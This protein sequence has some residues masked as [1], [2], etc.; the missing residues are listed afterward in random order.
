[1]LDFLAVLG[2]DF[3]VIVS[4]DVPHMVLS[5][6]YPMDPPYLPR[7]EDKNI[8]ELRQVISLRFSKIFYKAKLCRIRNN[9]IIKVL[10]QCF[11]RSIGSDNDSVANIAVHHR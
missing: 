6:C 2:R 7:Q 10:T 3:G 4:I 8:S 5:V 9:Q 1:M 11:Q